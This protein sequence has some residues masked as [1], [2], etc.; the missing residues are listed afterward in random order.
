MLQANNLSN[1][2]DSDNTWHI[3]VY[4]AVNESSSHRSNLRSEGINPSQIKKKNM[5][6]KHWHVSTPI[7]PRMISLQHVN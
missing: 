2:K 3:N 7:F 6:V 1:R 5:G 4:I